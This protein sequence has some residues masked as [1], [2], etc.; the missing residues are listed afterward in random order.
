MSSEPRRALDAIIGEL[1]QDVLQLQDR[2]TDLPTKLNDSL[3]PAADRMERAAA[4]IR[5]ATEQ[6]IQAGNKHQTSI[7]EYVEAAAGKIQLMTE[8]AAEKQVNTT[9]TKPVETQ[10]LQPSPPPL[11]KP[12]KT[13]NAVFWIIA[14]ALVAFVAGFLAGRLS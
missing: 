7:S 9:S 5:T 2:I 13:S 4:S 10:P 14:S 11:Q 1:L 12:Q 3:N 8:Q 6:L